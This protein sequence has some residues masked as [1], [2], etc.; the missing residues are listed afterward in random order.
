VSVGR[1]L[2]GCRAERKSCLQQC[3]ALVESYIP[4]EF[5]VFIFVGTPN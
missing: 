1:D 4:V 2:A 3:Y 5:V